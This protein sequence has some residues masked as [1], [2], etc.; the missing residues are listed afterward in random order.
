[1]KKAFLA[2][3]LVC[4]V[5]AAVFLPA[6][7]P[8][9][10]YTYSPTPATARFMTNTEGSVVELSSGREAIAE[11]TLFYKTTVNVGSTITPP[12][13]SP[14]R[15]GYRF[16]GWSI[17]KEGAE[18]F[19]FSTPLTGS[20]NL[21]ATWERN[22][23]EEAQETYVEPVLT[24]KEKIDES[25]PFALNGVCNQP[26]EEGAVSLTTAGIARLTASSDDVRSLLNYT[27]AS[28]TT[29]KSAVYSAGLVTV[30]YS[31]GGADQKIEVS[32]NDVTS[33]LVVTSAEGSSIDVAGFEKKAKKYEALSFD[34]YKVVMGG[35]S[36]MENWSDST[37]KMAPVTTKNV[38]IGGSSS[39]HWANCYADRLII[40]YNPRAVVLYVG[41]NDIINFHKTGDQT[42]QSLIRLFEHLHD[43]L[44]EATVHFILINKVPG[45][46]PQHKT[47]IDKANDLVIE[48]AKTH[49]Y[50]NIIDAGTVLEKDSGKYSE[51]YFLN[52][53]LHMSQAGYVLWGAEVRKAVIADDEERYG[54]KA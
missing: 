19:D 32:V 46:Y 15:K 17:D 45:Y 33:E 12:S 18:R 36:S 29:L 37:V 14:E 3:I 11:N 53:G 5:L 21:Y 28:A 41:I 47:A 16:V 35:S 40:P 20:L 23:E 42:A 22:Q 27:R 7:T 9:G 2:L 38:G 6:C 4:S 31:A 52:D 34:S 43:R 1:M 13:E 39:Y 25:V 10:S 26:V 54:N 48:Y 50:L 30:T 44:P 24:F 8:K 51:A 49:E